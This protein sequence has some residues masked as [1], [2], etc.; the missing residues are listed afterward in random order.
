MNHKL[1]LPSYRTRFLFVQRAL[2]TSISEKS[3]HML[4]L[5]SGEGDYDALISEHCT[6]LYSCDVNADDI[7][8]AKQLNA[9]ISNAY[10]QV[11]DAL[12]LSF[13]DN[14]FDSLVSIDVLEHVGDPQKMISEV[15]RVLRFGGI[16]IITFPKVQ[17]PILYDPINWILSKLA[18]SKRPIGAYAYGHDYLV[19]EHEFA[20]WAKQNNFE[21]IHSENL[22]GPLVGMLEMY[23]P[24]LIQRIVKP[25]ARNSSN[26]HKSVFEVRPSRD[27]P[28][29]CILTDW[30]I[31]LDRTLLSSKGRSIGK[32]VVLKNCNP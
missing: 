27:E 6:K 15:A 30:L 4:N 32:G 12:N 13:E 17:F 1:L 29:L 24:S 16:A 25:N 9:D 18:I 10:Y 19:C 7:N 23:W 26:T 5:G 8:Y 20:D 22:S 28:K 3:L 2:N 21:I 14:K 11:E 31:K